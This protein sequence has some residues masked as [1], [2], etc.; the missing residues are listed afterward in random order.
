MPLAPTP[1]ENIIGNKPTI[2][3]KEVIKIGR[4]R[5]L[6]PKTAAQVMLI[7]ILRRSKANSVIKIAFLANKP[8]NIIKAIC[9]YMLFDAAPNIGMIELNPPII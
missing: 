9:V 4:K 3:A 7:P 2:I 8:I 5:A 1:N 6:A